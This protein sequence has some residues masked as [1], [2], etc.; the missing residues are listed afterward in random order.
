MAT[1]QS[2][3]DTYEITDQD[4]A[5]ILAGTL[6]LLRDRG[7][8]VGIRPAP[9]NTNRPT[10][11]MVFIGGVTIEDGNLIAIEEATQ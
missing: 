1:K 11:L 6:Q 9:A 2:Q 3:K 8:P 7:L 5:D 10:G 4:A